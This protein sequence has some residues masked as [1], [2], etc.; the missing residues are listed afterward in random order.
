MRE[1]TIEEHAGGFGMKLWD[2]FH[3]YDVRKLWETKLDL[4]D[5]NVDH[6]DRGIRSTISA[7]KD[8]FLISFTMR[9]D[10]VKNV[11]AIADFAE[12][13]DLAIAVIPC[14]EKTVTITSVVATRKIV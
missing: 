2:K 8:G 7:L 9:V 11:Q 10:L 5:S 3:L 13:S 6:S 1:I 14:D 4:S 12:T